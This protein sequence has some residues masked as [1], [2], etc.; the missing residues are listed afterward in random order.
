MSA[1]KILGRDDILGKAK[2]SASEPTRVRVKEWDGV[3]LVRVMSAAER[4]AWEMAALNGDGINIRA[5][6]VAMTVVNEAG[7]L[8]ARGP[9]VVHDF[10][11]GCTDGSA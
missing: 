2:A 4:D 3:A 10:V 1:P 8:Y 11:E 9:A 7:E 5:T 6:L